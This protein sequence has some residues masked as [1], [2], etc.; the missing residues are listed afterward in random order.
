MTAHYDN[1][2]QNSIIENEANSFARNLLAPLPETID[3]LF[4]VWLQLHLS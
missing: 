4:E 3:Y 1:D 2:S